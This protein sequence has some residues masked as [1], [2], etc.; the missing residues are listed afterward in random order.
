MEEEHKLYR[1]IFDA[2]PFSLMLYDAERRYR[3]VN[4]RGVD[5]CGVSS[6]QNILGL[7]DEEAFASEVI[8]D[9]LSSLEETIKSGSEQRTSCR[10]T[11]GSESFEQSILFLPLLNQAQEVEYVLGVGQ[12]TTDL[13]QFQ[14]RAENAE[15]ELRSS[16]HLLARTFESLI[17]AVFIV[18]TQDRRVIRCNQAVTRILGYAPEELMGRT[19]EFFHVDLERF[20][21]FGE[22]TS[23][24]LR[25]KNIVNLEYQ[26]RH[27]DGR[28]ID[29]E[30]TV[31]V[32]RRRDGE[33][34]LVISVV[35][36][37]TDR[38]AYRRKLQASRSLE[39]N[40]KRQIASILHDDVIQD[41]V[42]AGMTLGGSS[43]ASASKTREHLRRA[44]N[45]LRTT[46]AELYPPSLK[47]LGLV[48]AIQELLVEW[49]ERHKLEVRFSRERAPAKMTETLQWTLYRGVREALANV[50]KHANA[51]SVA[52]TLR[53]L[54][55]QLEV[56]VED[57][58]D[59]IHDPL[60]VQATEQGG[61][62]LFSLRE[63][64][65]GLGGQLLVDN[66]TDLGGARLR[67]FV[68]IKEE[69]LCRSRS[70]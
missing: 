24:G 23:S 51:S 18:S 39:E 31:T 55:A 5:V 32:S 19:T 8:E 22:L 54:R 58:G 28:I 35:R 56:C 41:L 43:E 59:G 15:A 68:P 26:L 63:N 34:E 33:P 42:M 37:I 38:I 29:T 4:K 61:F 64:L 25:T 27:K 66:G 67:M 57:D 53:K 46:V 44:V 21:T 13:R 17:E 3:L 65:R 30:H 50:V 16:Q 70:T 20:N 52:V 36:D 7:K 48:E 49:N 11:T 12:D 1:R 6:E 62:G 60:P 9:Y 69:S 40:Y 47:E 45:R 14:R 10:R 2:V